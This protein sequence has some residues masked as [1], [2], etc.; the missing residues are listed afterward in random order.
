MIERSIEAGMAGVIS[1]RYR[2]RDKLGE[3]GMGAVYRA[4]DRLTGQIVALKRVTI[5]GDQ[6]QFSSKTP[7][8]DF[9]LSLAQE[10]RTLAG[11][12]HPHI[13][14]VLDYGFDEDR[15]PYFTMQL[16]E[17]A[18]S[19]TEYAATL[20]IAGKV[21][22]LSEM[23]EA[24]AYLHRRGIIHCDLKPANVLVTADGVVKVMDFGLSINQSE[25][26]DDLP[27]GTAGT[28]AYMAPELFAEHP[29]TVQSDLYAVG[30]I[31]YE[32]FA[33]KHPFHHDNFS[34]MLNSIIRERPDTTMLDFDLADVLDRLLAKAP[35]KRY[36]DADAVIRA[37]CQ[38]TEQP[39]PE[40]NA[41][42]R[43]S[44]LQA[45]KFV[46]RDTESGQLI[47]AL[48]RVMN[49][50][51]SGWLV[52]GESGVGK[53]RLLDELRTQALVAGAVVLRG[54][55]VEGGG[56]LYQLWRDPLRRLALAT[57]LSDLEASVLKSPV[58]DIDTLIGRSIAEAPD[59]PGQAGQLRLAVTIAEI[60]KRQSS[61]IV[62][63][64]EDLHWAGE[65]VMPLKRLVDIFHN[66]PLLIVGTYRDDEKPDLPAELPEMQTIKLT[67]LSDDDIAELSESMLG[68]AGKQPELL[69]LLKRETEGNTFFMVEVVRAL[70]EEAGRLSEVGKTS[71][72]AQVYA[73]GVEAVVRR[74]L[75]RLPEFVRDWLK[76]AAVAGRQIDLAVL[77]QSGEAEVSAQDDMLI[78]CAN[79]AVL[80]ISDGQWRFSHDKLRAAVLADLTADERVR[81][82]RQ[83]AEAIERVY[84]GNVAD[85]I[86]ADVLM[87]HWYIAD[88]VEKTLHYTL[89]SCERLL[90]YTADPLTARHLLER[91]LQ[92][93]DRL[94]SDNLYRARLTRLMGSTYEQSG[95]YPQAKQ[96][97]EDALRLSLVQ[98]DPPTR[99]KA[100]AGLGLIGF[101][102]GNYPVARD[103]AVQ[104]LDLAKQVNDQFGI[105][106]S[107]HSLG[108]VAINEG[109]YAAARSY[110]EQSL[111]I[112]QT[113]GDRNGI[114]ASLNNLGIVTANLG[115]Y[116]A[117]RSYHE[118]S[119]AIRQNI[120]DR[121]G[122]ATSLN[123]L[124]LVTEEQGDHLGAR[125]Y[126]EQSL[127]IK[128]GIG[129]RNGVA[130][131]L[132]NLGVVANNLRD[133]VAAID[134]FE[135]SMAIREA[136]GDRDGIA[137]SLNNIG[138][139]TAEMGDYN[140]ARDT[141]NRALEMWR[142]VGARSS[143]TIALDNIGFTYLGLE[144]QVEAQRAFYEALT[145]AHELHYLSVVLEVLLGFAQIRLT[146]GDSDTAAAWLG[147]VVAHPG[148]LVNTAIHRVEPLK[149]KL[150]AEIGVEA[151]TAAMERGKTL[152]LDT[153]VEEIL[154]GQDK[155]SP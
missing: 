133:F 89:L 26:G 19:L 153:V 39:V 95:D 54:Q 144:D 146:A 33:G 85:E 150:E 108:N 46:G 70:A 35:E 49:G 88:N 13:V 111:A 38:A 104:A 73:S 21:R 83:V 68:E 28:L 2:L 63:L 55:A 52:G 44:F 114:A 77:S 62:L 115:D 113:I 130:F 43:E 42:L 107:L 91:G 79:V 94:T 142:E 66:V 27:P 116:A 131:S 15:Q 101:R 117:A 98:D 36:D 50:K 45:A 75:N 71:L 148:T 124:G 57:E 4:D 120:G 110:Y 152:D 143:I 78:R 17:E 103:F 41:S 96:C 86:Y 137:W 139:V 12:R 20:N 3:G 9:R 154:A 84:P 105:A 132:S 5:S 61:P 100:L 136:I 122:I 59:L 8:Q 102:L 60:F 53:S 48:D 29:P 58:P 11:L 99:I 129:D 125:A 1:S 109:D 40:E 76:R 51:G 22:V 10:F 149:A 141:L 69:E 18:Q 121:N 87:E 47:A 97:Y 14:S 16:I 128:E 6:L 72:P 135:Q 56:L 7:Q 127:S 32:I 25:M 65:S 93:T 34:L 126:Y 145:I 80:E 30:V 155:K 106:L 23:L 112:R 118:Q 140:G 24:L 92:L 82:H 119:L 37:L 31:A 64:L 90:F 151:L 81:L 147:L 67:R 123:N 74:R 138:E 134:Y